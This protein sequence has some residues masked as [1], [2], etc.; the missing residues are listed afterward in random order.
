MTAIDA[1]KALKVN[2]EKI[3][4]D[5]NILLQKENSYPPSYVKPYTDLIFM[6]HSNFAPQ[7]YKVPFVLIGLDKA[8]DDA[9]EHTLFVR[10][11]IGTYGGGWYV[12]DSGNKVDLPDGNGYY[13]LINLIER[14]KFAI[15]TKA[16]I[17]GAGTVC[18]PFDYGTY[19]TEMTYPYWYGYLSFNVSIP[20]TEYILE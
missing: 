14:I 16:N 2:I 5:Q 17:D 11:T 8:V 6:P 4:E 7:D 12:D 15:V 19:D 9:S 10:L 1:L 20:A 3:I 18:K 13:D